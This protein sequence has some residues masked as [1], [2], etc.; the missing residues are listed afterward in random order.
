MKDFGEEVMKYLKSE[1]GKLAYD[2]CDKGAHR[3]IQ[4]EKAGVVEVI[5]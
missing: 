3:G 5:G 4:S 1:G 2:F